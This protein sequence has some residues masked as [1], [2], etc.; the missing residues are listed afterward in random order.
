MAITAVAM[1]AMNI[2]LLPE[3]VLVRGALVML[4]TK[5]LPACAGRILYVILQVLKYGIFCD[6]AVSGRK[7]PPA[8]KPL[9]PVAFLQCGE[10]PLYQV[11][12]A[13]L[14]FAHEVTH[15]KL[16]RD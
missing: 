3:C 6:G 14:H 9:S 5:L 13:P 11:R 16:R 8:P 1:I 2:L 12:R 15:R 7:V 4:E 10:F